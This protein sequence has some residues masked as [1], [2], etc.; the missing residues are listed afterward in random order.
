MCVCVTLMFILEMLNFTMPS[1]AVKYIPHESLIF[2]QEYMLR[3]SS[4]TTMKSFPKDLILDLS[5]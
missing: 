2:T 5:R 1:K 4:R 3:I